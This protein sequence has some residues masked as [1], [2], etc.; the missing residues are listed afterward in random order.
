MKKSF[1]L[2]AIFLI[3]SI[4]LFAQ[5]KKAAITF[6]RTTHDFGDIEEENGKATTEFEF[7]N[8]GNAPLLITRTAASCG[9]TTPEYPKEPIAPGKKGV[10][11]VTYNP[12]N[13]PGAFQK[14]VY[15]YANTDPERSS[16]VIKGKVIPRTPKKEDNYPREIGDLK[17]KKK[18]IPF[19]D[20]YVG[21]PKEEAVEMYNPS[22]KPLNLTF[23][24]LPKHIKVEAQPNPVPAMGEA[25]LKVTYLADKAKDWG[26]RS[27]EFV[28]KI[29]NEDNKLD[30]ISVSADIREDFSNLTDKQKANAPSCFISQKTVDFGKVNGKTTKK[31]IITN[32]GKSEMIVR[33]V[34]NMNG[35]FSF[36]APQKAIQPGKSSEIEITID[37]AKSSMK[38]FNSVV[39]IITNDPNS[40]TTTFKVSGTI[41]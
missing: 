36:S 26:I 21:I 25:K 9:C 31:L 38:K 18:H 30:K 2:S 17:L 10:V 3:I 19:Y 40:P 37:P 33:K 7:T 39:F 27:D 13:R 32:N 5:D 22:S 12:A 23:V 11:K 28:V 34:K 4:A 20:V 15:V 14:Q 24:E 29:N 6:S 16:L 35:M 41:D 1:T 8:T